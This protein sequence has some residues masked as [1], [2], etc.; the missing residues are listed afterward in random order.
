VTAEDMLCALEHGSICLLETPQRALF[1]RTI[2]AIPSRPQRALPRESVRERLPAIVHSHAIEN[3]LDDH[4]PDYD[5]AQTPSYMVKAML[6]ARRELIPFDDGVH[7]EFWEKTYPS[8]VGD[9]LEMGIPEVAASIRSAGDVSDYFADVWGFLT[10][11]R[12]IERIWAGVSYPVRALLLRCPDEHEAIEIVK[13]I[14]SAGDTDEADVS[15]RSS[16]VWSMIRRREA[17]EI[18]RTTKVDR[19][20]GTNEYVDRIRATPAA[21][22]TCF[23]IDTD[24]L[25][26]EAAALIAEKTAL[27]VR[28]LESWLDNIDMLGQDLDLRPFFSERG[29]PSIVRCELAMGPAFWCQHKQLWPVVFAFRRSIPVVYVFERSLVVCQYAFCHFCDLRY[30]ADLSPKQYPTTI[31]DEDGTASY[32]GPSGWSRYRPSLLA[33]VVN[34]ASYRNVGTL[35]KAY[36]VENSH[37]A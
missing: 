20:A 33:D 35:A 37:S 27:V 16:L 34:E 18:C 12:T 29:N 7:S 21:A 13:K 32:P 11:M 19:S 25:P 31:V 22:E 3:E 8:I 15:R 10:E 36:A 2:R 23:V 4:M 26:V 9:W 5:V 17:K 28:L 30:I 1:E 6:H 24:A 14:V